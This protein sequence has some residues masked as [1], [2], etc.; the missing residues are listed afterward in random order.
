MTITA[1]ELTERILEFIT[2]DFVDIIAPLTLK[3][4]REILRLWA[5]TQ[6]KIRQSPAQGKGAQYYE[7]MS[8]FT[9][10]IVRLIRDGADPNELQGEFDD[11]VIAADCDWELWG[12]GQWEKATVCSICGSSVPRICGHQDN[13]NQKIILRSE[14]QKRI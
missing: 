11:A 3:N 8:E 12:N 1:H 9:E 10:V 5:E 6:N 13:P 2:K 7:N 14:Y 4:R